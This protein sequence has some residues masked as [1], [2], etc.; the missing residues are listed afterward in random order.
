MKKFPLLSA[1]SYERELRRG[2][3]ETPHPRFVP[4]ALVKKCEAQLLENH[5][6]QSL[7]VLARRSGLSAQELAHAL[8]GEDPLDRGVRLISTEDAIKYLNKAIE[9]LGSDDDSSHHLPD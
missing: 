8:K 3:V 7:D 5:C 6:N 2:E 4:W 9:E 1:S